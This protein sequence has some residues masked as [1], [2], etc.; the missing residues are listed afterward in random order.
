MRYVVTEI[1]GYNEPSCGKI[2]SPQG[3]SCHVIDTLWNRRMIASFR[4][5]DDTYRGRAHYYRRI[6]VREQSQRLC[7]ELNRAEEQQAA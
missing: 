1:E 4:T 2:H 5:E 3:L 6:L 7:D